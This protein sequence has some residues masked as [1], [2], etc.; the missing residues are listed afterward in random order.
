MLSG[1]AIL[2]SVILYIDYKQYIRS[3]N[4]LFFTDKS[5]LEKDLR[6]IQESEVKQKLKT[7][8]E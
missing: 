4:G 8:N 1:F 2:I 7:L 5:K 3:N 6:K